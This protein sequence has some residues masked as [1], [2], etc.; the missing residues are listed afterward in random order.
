MV[1][2]ESG[3][4]VRITVLA[5]QLGMSERFDPVLRCHHVQQASDTTRAAVR[6]SR[7]RRALG[8]TA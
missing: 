7:V 2:N 3:E 4:R 8:A 1:A 5:R 6:A